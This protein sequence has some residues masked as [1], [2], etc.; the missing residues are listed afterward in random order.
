MP[1]IK[2]PTSSPHI[3][4]TPMVD[5]FSLLLTFFMLTTSFKPTEVA[6][7]DTPASISE[8][9]APDNNIMTISIS[10][11]NKLYFNIDNGIDT[12]R[13]YRIE[14]LK[15]MGEYY[16]IVFTPKELAKFEKLSGFGFP[17]QAMKAWINAADQKARDE[18][19]AT[20]EKDKK[21]GIPID[22]TDN[23]FS[24]WIL[25][26]RTANPDL[27]VAIKADLETEY[28]IVKKVLDIL[29]EKQVNKFNLVTNMEKVEVKMEDIK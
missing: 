9:Q 28:E 1:K 8:K 10:K 23:Q 25:F 6:V 3:D 18:I 17:I 22:S 7:I 26:A 4:M 19:Q 20:L 16:K 12:S 13:H 15:K 27:Q 24:N 14:T 5:L 11:V 21:D 29:Q 2:L